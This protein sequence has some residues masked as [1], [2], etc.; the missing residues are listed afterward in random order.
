MAVENIAPTPQFP[1]KVGATYERKMSAAQAGLRGPLRFEE[2]IATDTDVPNDFQLGLDQGYDT[3]AG[4]PNHNT[5]VFEKPAEETMRERA[6]VG[7]AA[8]VEAPTYLGEFSQGN[9]GDHSQVVIEEVVRSG[10]RYQRLNPAQV[11]D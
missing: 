6:H 5:N 4:R 1:E 9:F 11:A 8:W 2:G 7:S 10:G 3:P